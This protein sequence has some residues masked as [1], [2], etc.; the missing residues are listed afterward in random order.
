[1]YGTFV[2]E[3]DDFD[4]LLYYS[5]SAD[6]FETWTTMMDF[7]SSEPDSC[8]IYLQSETITT[9]CTYSGCDYDSE[10]AA[11]TG[12][13]CV[14]DPNTDTGE[15]ADRG[16]GTDAY[17]Y[18]SE[19]TCTLTAGEYELTDTNDGVDTFYF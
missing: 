11:V 15:K 2:E 6:S 3:R 12:L 16:S 10:A 13:E 17:P 7:E 1:M 14:V 9:F 4:K 18:V 8:P 5:L 19:V